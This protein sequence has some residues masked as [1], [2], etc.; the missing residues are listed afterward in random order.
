MCDPWMTSSI[1]PFLDILLI[2]LPSSL[3]T[4]NEWLQHLLC[5]QS[6]TTETSCFSSN[7]SGLLFLSVALSVGQ[8]ICLSLCEKVVVSLAVS[9]TVCLLNVF[10]VI[11]ELL[12]FHS[13]C[14]SIYLFVG[15]SLSECLS[16]KRFLKQLIW[17]SVS[18]FHFVTLCQFV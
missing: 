3:F 8:S 11:V 13:F 9:W 14:P 2:L 10:S 1:C 15:L 7:R 16:F 12:V 17:L 6:E 18:C 4:D 5:C